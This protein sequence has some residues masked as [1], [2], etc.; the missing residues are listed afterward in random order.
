MQRFSL[1]LRLRL[2]LFTLIT[3]IS[4]MSYAQTTNGFISFDGPGAGTGSG[5]GTTPVAINASR[6]IALNVI[7][8]DFSGT[9]FLRTPHAKFVAITP[10]NT[11]YTSLLALNST[12]QAVGTFT[13]TNRLSHG[14]FFDPSG[15]YFQ[16]DPPGSVAF[17]YVAGVNDSGLVAGGFRSDTTHGF[18]WL[19]KNPTHYLVFDVPGSTSTNPTGINASGQVAGVYVDQAS[20]E[21]R[22]FIRNADGTFTTFGLGESLTFLGVSAINASG[23]T[24]GTG[25]DEGVTISFLRSP[26]NN[27]LDWGGESHGGFQPMSM[28]DST[29]IVGYEFSEGGG[30][31]AFEYSQGNITFIP[32]PFTNTATSANGINASGHMTGTY[33]DE[34]GANHGWAD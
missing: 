34:A 10:P 3:C 21:N 18:L 2:A 28:N 22:G 19:A 25:F 32:I 24:T 13:D 16:L 9:A 23:Q 11:T 31:A 6:Y 4:A 17:V 14:F 20:N 5:Q 1:K 27:F 33:T 15:A 26:S 30:N 8:D 29:Q 12:G 7:A